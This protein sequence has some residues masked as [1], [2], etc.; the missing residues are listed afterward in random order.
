M[1]FRKVDK[2]IT[3]LEEWI[4]KQPP[5]PR[6]ILQ[7]DRKARRITCHAKAWMVLLLTLKVKE[8]YV[9]GGPEIL[10][11]HF[12]LILPRLSRD[13]ADTMGAHASGFA[14]MKPANTF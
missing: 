1:C 13:Q 8:S 7:Q 5:I 12:E 6:D 14:S 11:L 10:E 4:D 9:D 2:R 3:W